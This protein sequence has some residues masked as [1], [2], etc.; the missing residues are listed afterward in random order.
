MYPAEIYIIWPNVLTCISIFL[1]IHPLQLET[2]LVTKSEKLLV[3]LHNILIDCTINNQ[4]L[5]F[6]TFWVICWDRTV[7]KIVIDQF[8]VNSELNSVAV[9][10]VP[11]NRE[12]ENKCYTV[13]VVGSWNDMTHLIVV[14]HRS[15]VQHGCR[16]C[17]NMKLLYV[18]SLCELNS[19]KMPLSVNYLQL[20]LW[21]FF[22]FDTKLTKTR[23][24][25]V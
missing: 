19:V 17:A 9:C 21:G 25:Q 6:L 18:Q 23:S 3:L 7:C 4:F 10:A 13:T 14:V 24:S 22:A 5:I 15:V 8:S 20:R 16:K 2:Q 1:K 12:R 11:V